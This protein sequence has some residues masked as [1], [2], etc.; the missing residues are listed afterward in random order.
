MPWCM[1]WGTHWS[2]TRDWQT[3]HHHHSHRRYP[4]NN[5]FVS[6]SVHGSP[7]G[8]CG[9]LPEYNDHRVKCRCNYNTLFINILYLRELSTEGVK[10]NNLI[11]TAP[12]LSDDFRGA[13]MQI[14]A[15]VPC[16]GGVIAS[17]DSVVVENSDFHFFRSLSSEHCTYMMATRQLSRDATVDDLGHIS[18]SIDCFTSNFS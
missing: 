15:G 10:N 13:D 8:E 9:L 7:T 3:H 14:F 16:G 5:L 12:A 17:N 18:R 1:A 4:R 11:Y 2:D 6:T